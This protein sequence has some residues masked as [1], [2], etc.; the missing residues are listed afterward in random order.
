MAG[1]LDMPQ[2]RGPLFWVAGAPARSALT[3]GSVAIGD[4]VAL[5]RLVNC[6]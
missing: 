4:D 6:L 2:V 1:Q 5:A 3:C